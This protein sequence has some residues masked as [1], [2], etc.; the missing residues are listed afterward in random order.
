M[1]FSFKQPLK[2]RGIIPFLTVLIQ[3]ID[4]FVGF[5]HFF[6][7][8]STFSNN[9]AI[10]DIIERPLRSVL[11][12]LSLLH[13]FRYVTIINLTKQK[14]YIISNRKEG[15][16]KGL[17][18]F[19]LLLRYMGT[20][21]FDIIVTV[22]SYLI[23]TFIFSMAYF[24]N[25]FQC[26]GFQTNEINYWVYIGLLIALGG[27]YILIFLYD[28]FI[29]IRD[30]IRCRFYQLFVDDIYY[31]RIEIYIFGILV[32][33]LYTSI[34]QLHHAI[35][36]NPTLIAGICN[37]IFF[38][39]FLF[40]QVIFVL[41]FT[42]FKTI[43]DC[44]K[45]KPKDELEEILKS[46][47]KRSYF[48]KFCQQEFSPENLACYEDINEYKSKNQEEK[49]K[50]ATQIF[51]LYVR[52]NAELEVNFPGPIRNEINEKIQNGV[53]EK[54]LFDKLEVQII[55]NLSDTYSRFVY[56]QEYDNLLKKE[57]FIKRNL[58]IIHK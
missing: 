26:T 3:F 14:V 39:L 56:T 43:Y 54:D 12:I 27:G 45:R 33:Y 10:I 7:P 32:T 21:W 25:N 22:L 31:F 17:S 47:E 51:N 2:S 1:L 35:N 13:F 15:S 34:W 6:F 57:T 46:E 9:C 18:I 20:W 52:L 50:I 58:S 41:V 44:L 48:R 28:F 40:Y 11:F 42:I 19:L 23:F 29:N 49:A 37:G 53:F 55:V 5:P 8:L 24:A 36:N 30:I 38:N 4:L 16:R